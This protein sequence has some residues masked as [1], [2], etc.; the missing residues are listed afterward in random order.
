MTFVLIKSRT[1]S[2]PVRVTMPTDAGKQS[3]NE[4]TGKFRLMPADEFNRKNTEWMDK[5]VE[6]QEA[7]HK[8]RCAMVAEVL[9]GW[10]GVVDE[11]NQPVPFTDETL[12]ALC[13]YAIIVQAI[14]EAYKAAVSTEGQKKR[15]QGN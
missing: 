5:F 2:W 6:D 13:E 11:D 1:F 14:T 4:F 8:L 3:T 10:D 7:A 9:I 12:K 15:R